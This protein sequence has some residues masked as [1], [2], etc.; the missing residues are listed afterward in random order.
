MLAVENRFSFSRTGCY[1]CPKQIGIEI[2][3]P[4]LLLPNQESASSLCPQLSQV[5]LRPLTWPDQQNYDAHGTESRGAGQAGDANS[6][7]VS[8]WLDLA[9]QDCAFPRGLPLLIEG[10]A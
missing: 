5:E 3:A 8:S 4:I 10:K 2:V 1:L 9:A 7:S 6:L